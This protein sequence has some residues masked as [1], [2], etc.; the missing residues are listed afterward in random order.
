MDPVRKTNR[1]RPK[2]ASLADSVYEI[3]L[4]Q[5]IDGTRSAGESLNIDALARELEVSPT[6]IREALARLEATGMVRRTALKG[7]SV[8]P[9]FTERELAD[10]MDARAAI[11]PVNARLACQ[12][13][14][15]E[16]VAALADTVSELEQARD[17]GPKDEYHSYWAADDRFHRLIAEHSE[18]RFL[19]AA[20]ESLGGHVQRFRLFG[21]R[22][23]DDLPEA[24]EEHAAI[25]R[26]FAKGN[27][28]RAEEMMRIHISRVK[29]RALIDREA[30]SVD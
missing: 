12:R 16:L 10:L 24:V 22:R 30:L 26:E 1:P 25:L 15:S 8:A 20:Y 3:L 2:R 13:A 29:E 14:T 23:A 18:N 21:A 19:A 28:A 5:L 6:P 9:L 27:P 17:C 4:A 11:E 7:Y